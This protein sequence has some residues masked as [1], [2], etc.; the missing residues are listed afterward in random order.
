MSN[1]NVFPKD[2]KRTK[3]GKHSRLR[4]HV[5]S[6]ETIILSLNLFQLYR[7]EKKVMQPV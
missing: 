6:R 7:L 1:E 2:G 3:D 4:N 5:R